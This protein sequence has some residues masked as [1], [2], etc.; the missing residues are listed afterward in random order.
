MKAV[1]WAADSLEEG[2]E[3][4]GSQL[5]QRLEDFSTDNIS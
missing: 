3:L 5:R 2:E 1:S 4:T